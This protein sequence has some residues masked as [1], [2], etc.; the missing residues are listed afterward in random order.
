VA[1]YQAETGERRVAGLVLASLGV[2]GAPVYDKELIAQ[3][4]K[5]VAAGAGEDLLHLP[6]RS[7]PAFISAAT[8]L[9]ME[10]SP[11][12][13]KDFFG[14]ETEAP[15]ILRVKCPIL[16]FFGT[17]DDVGGEKELNLLKAAVQRHVGSS[18]NIAT[19]MIINGD[20]MYTGEE[21]QVAE[22]ISHWA[23]AELVK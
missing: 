19:T 12:E 1:H 23:E 11:P 10:N 14:I 3:A 2:G 13:Y 16:A 17:K 7:F 5:L 15:G 21:A 8:Y 9:D 20:H 18:R 6:N 22:K 4:K